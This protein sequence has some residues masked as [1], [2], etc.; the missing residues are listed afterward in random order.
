MIA[1]RFGQAGLGQTAG[2]GDAL[3]MAGACANQPRGENRCLSLKPANKCGRVRLAHDRKWPMISS[4]AGSFG[5]DVSSGQAAP[6][7][8]LRKPAQRDHQSRRARQALPVLLPPSRGAFNRDA[9]SVDTGVRHRAARAV[10]IR[11]TSWTPHRQLFLR[12]RER[13]TGPQAAG[14][15]RRGNG[16]NCGGSSR[17]SDHN[18]DCANPA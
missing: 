9:V 17:Q 1:K 6:A 15:A 13:Q 18:T 16:I 8:K 11:S 7:S 3:G 10:N 5:A 2:R 14:S 4:G 12:C